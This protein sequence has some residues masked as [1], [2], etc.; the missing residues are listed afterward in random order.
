LKQSKKARAFEL[1]SQ[2]YLPLSKEIKDLGLHPSNRYKYFYEWKALGKPTG[3]LPRQNQSAMVGTKSPGGETI[4]GID[5][6][7]VK[8]KTPEIL[9]QE[10]QGTED[11]EDETEGIEEDLVPE[12]AEPE[13]PPKSDESIG[14]V[15]EAGGKR[16]KKAEEEKGKYEITVADPGIK[17][18]VFLS[19]Q[20]LA[21]HEIAAAKQLE[22]SKDGEGKLL[23]G[24]F[25]DGCVETF[26]KDRKLKLGLVEL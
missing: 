22:L 14:G 6:T 17:C 23:L 7:Q 20:T 21:L 1:F 10:E 19:K 9:S 11:I 26:F 25:L 24:D 18:I 2:G 5:E 12:E 15:D 16:K 3:I 13:Q 4:G 8:H